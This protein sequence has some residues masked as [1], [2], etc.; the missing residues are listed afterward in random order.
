MILPVPDPL[1]LPWV[2][3]FVTLFRCSAVRWFAFPTHSP[4]FV[5]SL[6]VTGLS[7]LHCQGLT[8]TRPFP[9]TYRYSCHS[10]QQETRIVW[11]HCQDIEPE[12]NTEQQ[13]LHLRLLIDIIP[14]MANI[15]TLLCLLLFLSSCSGFLQPISC[16]QSRRKDF[17]QRR[18]KDNSDL[19]GIGSQSDDDGSALAKEFYQQLKKRQDRNNETDNKNELFDIYTTPDAPSGSIPSEEMLNERDARDLN[20]QAFSRRR[21]VVGGVDVPMKKFTGQQSAGFFS[22]NGPSVYSVP[23]DRSRQRM[24]QNEFNV[25]SRGEQSLYIQGGIAILMLCFFLYVGFTGGIEANSSI[26][27]VDPMSLEGMELMLQCQQ[28]KKRVCGCRHKSL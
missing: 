19:D 1:G 5:L 24:Q 15:C 20:R 26:D 7:I 3:P 8:G 25:A 17:W 4:L 6:F 9:S 16:V 14:I 10:R 21:E 12:N 2:V 11:Q 27:A 18:N 23:V 28:T 22:G 13:R